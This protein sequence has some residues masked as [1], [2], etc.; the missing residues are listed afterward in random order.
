[1]CPGSGA[2]LPS[3]RFSY[4]APVP[5]SQVGAWLAQRGFI[6]TPECLQAQWS[7]LWVIRVK[8]LKSKHI[9]WGR[10][11]WITTRS[12]WQLCRKCIHYDVKFLQFFRSGIQGKSI[13]ANHHPGPPMRP[14]TGGSCS[15]GASIFLLRKVKR[16]S[17]PEIPVRFS[18]KTDDFRYILLSTG[19]RS[20]N[21]MQRRI[22]RG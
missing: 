13:P 11:V 16:D 19:E 12:T 21:R 20:A 22:Q 5:W 6:F 14:G 3:G 1:M 10:A 17:C 2:R 18:G 4:H 8:P 9:C 15:I 7:V